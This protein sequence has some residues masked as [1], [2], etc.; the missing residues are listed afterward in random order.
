MQRF[1]AGFDWVACHSRSIYERQSKQI[2]WFGFL[3]ARIRKRHT[4]A[5]QGGRDSYRYV[6]VFFAM[7]IGEALNGYTH[8]YTQGAGVDASQVLQL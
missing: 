6:S 2:P 4:L 7:R 8:K 5:S 1:A 3:Y